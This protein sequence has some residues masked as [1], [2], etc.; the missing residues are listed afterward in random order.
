M[1]RRNTAGSWLDVVAGLLSNQNKRPPRVTRRLWAERLEGRAVLSVAPISV[2][3]PEN[4]ESL[5]EYLAQEQVMGPAVPAELAAPADPEIPAAAADHL[6]SV[7]Q[8][9]G[10]GEAGEGEGEGSGS[11]SGGSGRGSGSGSG[12]SEDPT[13][14]EPEIT[15]TGE[16][17]VTVEGQVEDDGNLED[18]TITLDG[19]I[20]NVSLNPDGTF[21]V[22]I[23]DPQGNTTF[24]I[25]VTD[26]DGN[27][28]TYTFDYPT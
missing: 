23:T 5:E 3:P 7:E 28:T 18:L 16:G 20:G 25:T 14:P 19:G 13:I 27:A 21:S 6:L 12:G 22:E 24:T 15:S 26:A 4:T 1:A 2:E 10:Y 11:G 9:E 17:G 8:G